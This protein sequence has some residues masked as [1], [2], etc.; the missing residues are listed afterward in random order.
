MNI[1]KSN[2]A[3]GFLRRLT[4]SNI[5]LLCIGIGI[6]CLIGC[7]KQES[8]VNKV[9]N[10]FR[11]DSLK[12]LL[13]DNLRT[14]RI[15]MLG[16]GEPGNGYYMRIVTGFLDRWL[17]QLEKEKAPLSSQEETRKRDQPLTPLP[18]KLVLF[19][20][21]DSERT[22]TI[23]HF[24]QTGN[25]SNWLMDAIHNETRWGGL[26]SGI[27]M[28]DIEYFGNLKRIEERVQK[29]NTQDVSHPYDFR[30]IGP[31]GV[32]PYDL[33]RTRDT[34][35]LR[36]RY[37]QFEKA[38]FEYFV[39]QRDEISSNTIRTTLNTNPDYKALIFYNP[40]HLLRGWQNKAPWEAIKGIDTAYGYFMAH[41]LDQYFSRDSVSTF[42]TNNY[43]RGSYSGIGEIERGELSMDYCVYG[44]PIP[45]TQCPLEIINCQTTFR[46][47]FE[48]MKKYGLGSSEEEQIYALTYSQL[49]AFHLKRSYLNSRPDVRP[50]LDSLQR[51]AQDTSRIA[52]KRRA[53]IADKLIKG[54]DAVQNINLLDK[55]IAIQLK[56]A[57]WYLPML[58]KVLT[59]MPSIEYKQ[60]EKLSLN[61]ESKTIILNHKEDLI[62]YF[63]V[64]LLWIGTPDENNRARKE[65]TSRTG[66]KLRTAEEWSAW[67]R[68]QYD[69]PL[70]KTF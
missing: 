23:R 13:I 10:Y 3:I 54:F 17:D 30:I 69:N 46:A 44:V 34:T 37:Q 25:I 43:P 20:E 2:I 40:A 48:L 14:K 5:K 27:S 6:L 47:R 4:Y 19:I 58:K 70:W 28:D 1:Q 39:R 41:Y 42:I 68:T 57:N 33:I 32:P 22:N 49:L 63:L 9:K 26:R 12:D 21:A 38:R 53:E 50:W 67:W 15:I 52:N 11:P 66:L 31:E 64:N 8:T 18:K 7:S 16:E 61:E 62:N 56:D 29:L 59:N 35:L 51:Y 24:L 55:W 45:P 60:L 65:L 36:E